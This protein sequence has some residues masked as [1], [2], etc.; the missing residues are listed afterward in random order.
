MTPIHPRHLARNSD[1]LTSH[2]AAERT[3]EFSCAHRSLVYLT[4]SDNYPKALGAEQI[5]ELCGLQAYQV[6]KRLPEL[7]KLGLAEPTEHTR[8]T[9][10]GR[11]ERLWQKV[12]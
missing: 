5:A 3:A 12:A 11:P 7:E 10:S 6:R 2:I 1:P 8:K 4:L 9:G